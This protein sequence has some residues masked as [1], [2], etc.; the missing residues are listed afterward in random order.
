MLIIVTMCRTLAA[1]VSL[2]RCCPLRCLLGSPPNLDPCST[3]AAQTG[4]CQIAVIRGDHRDIDLALAQ[5]QRATSAMPCGVLGKPALLR[6]RHGPR[7]STCRLGVSLASGRA[8][9]AHSTRQ[10]CAQCCRWR[11][12]E[13]CGVDMSCFSELRTAA[14]DALL[15]RLATRLRLP[16]RSA[17]ARVWHMGWRQV[18]C[19]SCS[20]VRWQLST[21]RLPLVPRS[22]LKLVPS[23]HRHRNYS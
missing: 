23:E 21:P 4:H 22:K 6:K 9:R 10:T 1:N 19:Q 18:R 16:N 14:F 8:G 12:L 15:V 2:P 5:P 17:S 7:S 11:R 3:A 20:V 13:P